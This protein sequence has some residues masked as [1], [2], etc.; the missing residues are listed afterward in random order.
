MHCHH[1][2]L[3]VGCNAWPLEQLHIGAHCAAANDAWMQWPH[4]DDGRG[5]FD[6]CCTVHATTA[7]AAVV[8]NAEWF[9]HSLTIMWAAVQKRR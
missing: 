3:L 7:D 1:L 5:T 6:G 4:Y 2:L 8:E 9:W